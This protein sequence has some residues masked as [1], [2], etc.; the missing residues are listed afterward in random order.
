[1]SFEFVKQNS[2]LIVIYTPI[3]GVSEILNK[4][5]IED[6]YNI[7]N[8][9]W[10][11]QCMLRDVEE[12]DDDSICFAI[13]KVVDGYIEINQAVVGTEHVFFFSE[14]MKFNPKMFVA[15]KNISVLKKIDQVID[16]NMYIGDD[17]HSD[18]YSISQSKYK[19]LIE[20]FPNSTELKK[21][22][23]K[24][25]ATIVKEFVPQSDKCEH[26]YE[27]YIEKREHAYLKNENLNIQ[28]F[29]R[30]IRREQFAIALSELKNLLEEAEHTCETVWQL[31]IEEIM[32]LLYPQYIFS[33]REIT[34][35][36]VDGYDKRPDFILVDANGFIDV[37]EIKKPSV[38]VLTK[39]AS[40][41]NNYVPVRDF[42]GA[43][44]QIE[45][46]IFCLN[47]LNREKDNFFVKLTEMLP[48][49]V[50][51]QVVNPQGI[52]IIGRSKEF[53]EQQIRDFEL[54]KRQYKNIADI[55]TYDDLISRFERIIDSLSDK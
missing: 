5:R 14:N 55:M 28:D 12:F 39:Q 20:I 27:N 48:Q 49:G 35:Q 41:R 51:P 42:A 13:G 1:M 52:L 16:G 43:I 37:M 3:Y 38:S 30:K 50:L 2:E 21:Y 18:G 10:V 36:G 17:E 32:K 46:Y 15:N 9:F 54:I 47:C 6:G 25:I 44:Q 34:F 29:N 8:T 31:R 22:A 7:K 23:H 4:I 24:R 11:E 45:K 53:D 26:E 19:A 33:T 40:Y